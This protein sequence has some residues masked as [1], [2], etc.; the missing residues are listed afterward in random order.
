MRA[1]IY[2]TAVVLVATVVCSTT[3][4]A[5]IPQQQVMTKNGHHD[6][7]RPGVRQPRWRMGQNGFER[8]DEM[9][10]QSERCSRFG[11]GYDSMRGRT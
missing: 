3:A 7:D 4:L 5:A 10:R 11:R 8:Y 6:R 1:K 9:V 2:P